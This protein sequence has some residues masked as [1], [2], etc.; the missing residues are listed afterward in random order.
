MFVK[1]MISFG[2][3]SKVIC[4]NGFQNKLNDVDAQSETLI[5]PATICNQNSQAIRE[6]DKY[7]HAQWWCWRKLALLKLKYVSGT[8]AS[9]RMDS[10]G[11][12]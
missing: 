4:E 3:M 10:A 5:K 1:F 2:N 9:Q 12:G 7:Y 8:E 6:G 11:W